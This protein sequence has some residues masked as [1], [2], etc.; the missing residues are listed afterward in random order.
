MA[1]KQCPECGLW[2]IETAV[3]C[4]CEYN[5]VT[6]TVP[7]AIREKQDSQWLMDIASKISNIVVMISIMGAV[8]FF[9]F[10]QLFGFGFDLMF[11][12]FILLFIGLESL[13]A[14]LLKSKPLVSGILLSMVGI[15][16][17]VFAIYLYRDSLGE[18]NEFLVI[19]AYLLVHLVCGGLAI[20]Y[21]WRTRNESG[22]EYIGS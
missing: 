11:S 7:D 14:I 8:L 6:G 5:F 10:L 18:V 2:S 13:A 4:D 22:A 17:I 16:G 12:L 3:K 19:S 15:G 9:G 1:D 20:A 21:W